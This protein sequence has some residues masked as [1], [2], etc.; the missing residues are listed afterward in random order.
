V[1]WL[2]GLGAAVAYVLD[3]LREVAVFGL[4]ALVVPTLSGLLSVLVATALGIRVSS[5]EV[6]WG[7][8]VVDHR[9][10]RLFVVVRSF[11]VGMGWGGQARSRRLVRTRFFLTYAVQTLALAATAVLA[12]TAWGAPGLGCAAALNLVVLALPRSDGAGRLGSVRQLVTI[13]RLADEEI[14]DWSASR[15][16]RAADRALFRG[17]DRGAREIAERALAEDDGDRLALDTLA[18]ACD[19]L[20]DPLRALELAGRLVEGGDR[21]SQITTHGNLAWF[22]VRAREAG[23]DLDA[24]RSRALAAL[25]VADELGD[26]WELH[27]TRCLIHALSGHPDPAEQWLPWLEGQVLAPE[28]VGHLHLTRAHLHHL[29]GDDARAEAEVEQA[30]RLMP[31]HA[32]VDDVQ[33]WVAR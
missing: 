33:R 11:P 31:S 19:R 3:G 9:G 4:A 23:H 24:W 13:P 32:R 25:D 30:R 14:V 12:F 21:A 22:L 10:E 20:G 18:L 29:R 26:R 5:V 8:A 15:L 16:A 2:V 17:D 7:Q 6:G 27:H 1:L 28:S